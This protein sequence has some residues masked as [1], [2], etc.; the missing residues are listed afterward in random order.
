MKTPRLPLNAPLLALAVLLLVACEGPDQK[1]LM[2][3]VRHSVPPMAANDTFFDGEVIAHLSLGSNVDGAAL[4]GGHGGGA[5]SKMTSFKSNAGEQ[6][7][8]T[9]GGEMGEAIA[10]AAKRKAKFRRPA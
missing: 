10:G 2:N 8:G 4:F 3:E 6:N 7:F 1:A 5:S 9:G